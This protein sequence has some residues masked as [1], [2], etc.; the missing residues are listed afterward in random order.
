MAI[1]GLRNS[2]QAG[3][4]NGTNRPENWRNTLLRLYPYGSQMAPLAA[5]TAAMSSEATDDPKY[6]WFRKVTNT[7]RFKLGQNLTG[8]DASG[9]QQNITIDTTDGN[10]YGVKMGDILMVEHTGERLYVS[11]TPTTETVVTVLRGFENAASQA[12]TYQG[13]GV[14]PWIMKIGSAFE[15]GSAAPD[16]IG[17]DP[18]EYNNQ[19]QIFR[20]TYGMT[21]TGMATRT[22][23]G[24]LIRENKTD[25]FEAF[26]QGLE[27]SFIFGIK[28]T[29]SKNNQPLRLTDGILN[30]LPSDRKLSVSTYNANGLVDLDYWESLTAT[31]FRYG[32]NEKMMWLGVTAAL[33]ITQMVRKNAQLQWELGP[34]ETEYGI[35][36]RRLI[37]PM[38]TL[39]MKI[40]PMFGQMTGGTNSGT[41]Y[42]GL[43]NACLIL[44][45]KNLKYRYLTGRD[46]TYQTN[47]QLPGVDGLLAGWLAE[48]GLELHHPETHLFITGIRGGKKDA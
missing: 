20:E 30:M 29:T 2:D 6:H 22:R 11:Q 31:M 21:G 14:N 9:T 8:G 38:G 12:V 23:T 1:P 27:R 26:N 25:C 17:W 45:M 15:E 48:C 33:A 44:D 24:E 4:P 39:V 40:H 47:L 3:N 36:I 34:T 32:S 5:L 35:K 16:P 13:A 19:T 43:D 42:P 28:R 10:I 7:H 41:F 37:T 46:V 18:T